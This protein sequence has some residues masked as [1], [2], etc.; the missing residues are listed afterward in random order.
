MAKVKLC[1]RLGKLFGKEWDLDVSTP[2][3]ALRAIDVNTKG[4]FLDYLYKTVREKELAYNFVVDDA[5]I[6]NREDTVIL[7]RKVNKD[8]VIKVVPVIGG[9]GTTTI[10]L[11]FISVALQI[12]SLLM[13][14]SPRVNYGD[15]DDE[16]ARKESYLFNGQN[17]TSRQGQAVP[18]GYG[19]MLVPP[20][21]LSLQYVY[22]Q[23]SDS[24]LTST[25][26]SAYGVS[27]K[28]QFAKNPYINAALNAMYKAIEE[29]EI[30][31]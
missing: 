1:G 16:S 4:K 13:A 9:S 22:T 18:V 15:N 2:R 10:I 8:S 30:P 23:N 14:P 11:A 6:H 29:E 3:E 28:Q 24:L 12:V 27:T 31:E 17:S 26:G 5:Y 20:M 25:G 21:L 7:N 19:R